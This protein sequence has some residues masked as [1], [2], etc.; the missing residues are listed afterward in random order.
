M[1]DERPGMDYGDVAKRVKRIAKLPDYPAKK[2]LINSL[3][4]QAETRE[5][6]RAKL[7]LQKMATESSSFSG[8]GCIQC[9]IGNGRK[10]GDGIWRYEGGKWTQV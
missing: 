2:N 8:R 6:K 10:F 4:N 9:G 3:I 1:S 7:S 5:G